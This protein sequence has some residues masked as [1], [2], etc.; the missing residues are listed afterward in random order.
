MHFL[1]ITVCGF[2]NFGYPKGYYLKNQNEA[3]HQVIDTWHQK[4][5]LKWLNIVVSTFSKKTYSP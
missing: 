2:S 5:D 1:F 3:F 4:S